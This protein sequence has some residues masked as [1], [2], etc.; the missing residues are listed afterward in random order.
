MKKLISL[1]LI[2]IFVFSFTACTIVEYDKNETKTVVCTGFPQYDFIRELTKNTD[3]SPILLNK[4][5][6]LHSYE[7]T[8]EDMAL[9]YKSDL[10]IYNDSE[11]EP[12]VED[13]VENLK[14]VYVFSMLSTV[15]TLNEEIVEGMEEEDEEEIESD[16][17]IWLSLKNAN[18]II[19]AFKNILITNFSE[20]EEQITKNYESYKNEV[21]EL[22]S[23]YKKTI[24]D[25]KGDTLIFGDRFP[26]RYLVE[27]YNLKYYAAFKG[28]SSE[29]EAS[30]ET[31]TFLIEKA[32]EKKS[33]IILKVDGSDGKVAKTIADSVGAKVQMLNSCQSIT[34]SDIENGV[35]YLDVMKSNLSVI[36]EALN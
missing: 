28:C 12:W 1:I 7:P 32:K 36:K 13:V 4:Q 9:I 5:S 3:I 22:D 30:F 27:D 24:E 23:L 25:A 16:K 26:F 20:N 14:D 33:K 8:V 19:E 29:T 6:D 15:K 34:I 10:F 31:I 21:S 11:T 2:M 18:S 17:H 35:T